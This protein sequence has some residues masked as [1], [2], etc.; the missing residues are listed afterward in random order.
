MRELCSYEANVN[1][2]DEEKCKLHCDDQLLAD[3]EK[4]WKILAKGSCIFQGEKAQGLY[5]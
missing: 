4:K 3:R 2:Y 1:T 5:M